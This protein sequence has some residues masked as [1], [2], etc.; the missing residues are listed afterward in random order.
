[1]NKEIIYHPKPDPNLIGCEYCGIVSF[2]HRHPP[3]TEP[4]DF[5]IIEEE[6]C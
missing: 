5:E 3:N 6:S 2:A 4:K 1:M